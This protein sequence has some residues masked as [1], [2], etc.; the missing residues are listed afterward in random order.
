MKNNTRRKL[1]ILLLTASVSLLS[2]CASTLTH[3]YREMGRPLSGAAQTVA[4]QSHYV[5]KSVN[6][7]FIAY[8]E[9]AH[10]FLLQ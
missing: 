4:E 7:M 1:H 5:L 9:L 3:T 6:D 8:P 2:G 10:I